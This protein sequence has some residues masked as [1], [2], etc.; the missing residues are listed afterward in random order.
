M[1]N[2]KNSILFFDGPQRSV[3]WTDAQFK[4]FSRKLR[5][6]GV[7]YVRTA[8]YWWDHRV[9]NMPMPWLKNGT[10]YDLDKPNQAYDDAL[11]RFARWVHAGTFID[12]LLG[13]TPEIWFDL[14]DNCASGRPWSPWINNIQGIHGIYEYNDKAIGYYKAWIKR[15]FGILGRRAHYG[16]GNELTFPAW[17]N[18]TEANKW[19]E[20]WVLGL[21]NYMKSLGMRL[22]FSFSADMSVGGTSSRIIGWLTEP[23]FGG[24]FGGRDGRKLIHVVHGLGLPEH[25]AEVWNANILSGNVGLGISEDGV[26]MNNRIIPPELRGHC[27]EPGVRCGVCRAGF[28]SLVRSV[29]RTKWAGDRLRLV[30]RMPKEIAMSYKSIDLLDEDVSLGVFDDLKVSAKSTKEIAGESIVLDVNGQKYCLSKTA[31]IPYRGKMD[32]VPL[33]IYVHQGVDDLKEG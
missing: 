29:L 27:E 26:G 25:W 7:K 10:Y 19:G 23:E 22:P 12:K 5:R 32:K 3:N 2:F 33:S 18:V 17:Q 6:H 4:K 30:E 8:P 9:P 11:R 31:I 13:G 28:V 21:A 20:K 16:L 24:T 14:F 1:A 15:I